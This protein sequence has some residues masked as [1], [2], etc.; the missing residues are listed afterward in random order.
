[1]LRF[2]GVEGEKNGEWWGE[3]EAGPGLFQDDRCTTHTI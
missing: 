3:R 1:M 2:E